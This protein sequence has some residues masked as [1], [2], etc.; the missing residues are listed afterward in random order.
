MTTTDDETRLRELL[1]PLATIDPVTRKA[2]RRRPLIVVVI[3][4][5]ALLAAGIALASGVNP[6]AGIGAADH[7]RG[8]KDMLNPAALAAITSLNAERGSAAKRLGIVVGQL[9][10]DSA[11]LVRKLSGGDRVYAI[12]TTT[13][14]LCVLIQ[15]P[16]GERFRAAI[17]CGAPLSQEQ[18]TTEET[19]QP[20]PETPPF[21]F[22]VARDDVVAVSFIVNGSE[23]TV[24]V[25]DNVWAYHGAVDLPPLTVHFSDGSTQ[26]LGRS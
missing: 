19:M 9:L 18:P 11:R 24:P 12:A 25:K 20:D 17:G 8:T 22:G 26:Q 2:K 23:Q 14:E 13:D 21:T 6:F 10:P 15:E 1:A 3:A 5:A 7:T 16:P 4:L